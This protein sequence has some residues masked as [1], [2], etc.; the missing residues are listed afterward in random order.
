MLGVAA[1]LV[2][3]FASPAS[4]EDNTVANFSPALDTKISPAGMGNLE[5]GG[6]F[7]VLA[8]G[9]FLGFIAYKGTIV[10]SPNDT[11]RSE[12]VKVP[13]KVPLDKDCYVL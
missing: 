10:T 2:V 1:A 7:S 13:L 9:S 5:K 11:V 3:T 8:T 6:G 12:G 4:A